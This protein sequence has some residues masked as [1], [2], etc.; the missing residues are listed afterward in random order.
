MHAVELPQPRPPLAG[1][2]TA[3]NEFERHLRLL[4][5]ERPDEELLGQLCNGPFGPHRIEESHDERERAVRDGVV[6]VLIVPEPDDGA[7]AEE[8]VGKA[9]LVVAAP[10]PRALLKRG[11]AR[12]VVRVHVGAVLHQQRRHLEHCGGVV[13]AAEAARA[14]H[15]RQQRRPLKR[16]PHVH[17]GARLEVRRQ[18]RGRLLAED[19]FRRRPSPWRE[20]GRAA[21]CLAWG[22]GTP[23]RTRCSKRRVSQAVKRNTHAHT[24]AAAAVALTGHRR[25]PTPA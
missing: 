25:A 10:Q 5:H 3:A 8:E 4:A 9:Q 7:G 15:E 14:R 22:T 21:K 17:V 13:A 23:P 11:V 24:H 18:V 1:R 6:Q 12:A 19:C 20:G 2:V 16:V